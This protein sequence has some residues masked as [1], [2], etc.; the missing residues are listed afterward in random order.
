MERKKKLKKKQ[1]QLEL[2]NSE[3]SLQGAFKKALKKSPGNSRS[4]NKLVEPKSG[5]QQ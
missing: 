3:L 5:P 4:Q 1:K 2:G